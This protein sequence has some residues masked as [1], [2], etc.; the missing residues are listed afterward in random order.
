MIP[1]NGGEF[2]CGLGET[3]GDAIG[4]VTAGGGIVTVT[5]MF[6]ECVFES[7]VPATITV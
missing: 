2:G 4:V 7:S 5:V 3:E 1:P 6:V